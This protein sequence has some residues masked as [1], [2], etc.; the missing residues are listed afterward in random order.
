E[1]LVEYPQGAG[2]AE[3]E[4]R[5]RGAALLALRQELAGKARTSQ[6]ERQQRLVEL[7]GRRR[8]AGY[9]RRVAEVLRRVELVLDRIEVADV[10]EARAIVLSQLAYVA[11]VPGDLARV[12]RGKPADDAQQA[13][14]AA[15]VRALHLQQGARRE[16]EGEVGKEASPAPCTF[17]AGGAEQGRAGAHPH[18]RSRLPALAR[19]RSCSA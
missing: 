6:P 11:A 2:G 5:E 10:G 3:L 9:L 4:A 18:A 14:L 12:G 15:A 1:G 8:K 17:Q 19:R 16:L 7:D 13:G